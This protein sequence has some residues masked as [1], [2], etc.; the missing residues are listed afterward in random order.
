M[1]VKPYCISIVH[2]P[3]AVCVGHIGAFGW[4]LVCL[5]WKCIQS[6][7]GILT[8]TKQGHFVGFSIDVLL[9]QTCMLNCLDGMIPKALSILNNPNL[10]STISPKV[11]NNSH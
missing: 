8:Q 3:F 11:T 5:S 6:S 9:G 4:R 2:S 10:A 7:N 1:V